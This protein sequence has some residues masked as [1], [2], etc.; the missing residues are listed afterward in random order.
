[1]SDDPQDPSDKPLGYD[2]ARRRA[3]RLASDPQETERLLS[4]AASKAERVRNARRVR[5]FWSDLTAL[6]RLVRARVRGEY[7]RLPWRAMISALAAIVYFVN[8]LDVIPDVIP[9]LG[10]VDDAAVLAFVLRMISGDISRFREWEADRE[11]SGGEEDP[12]S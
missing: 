7:E 2:G 4:R 3:E 9:F 1:M 12:A 10:Y 11:R 8:P 6:F 5:G